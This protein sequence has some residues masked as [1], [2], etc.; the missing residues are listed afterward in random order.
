MAELGLCCGPRPDLYQPPHHHPQWSRSR[1]I[2][3]I[4]WAH[5]PRHGFR[6]K[7]WLAEA[8]TSFQ[9]SLW[10]H[11]VILQ[12]TFTGHLVSHLQPIFLTSVHSQPDSPFQQLLWAVILS[13]LEHFQWRSIP[14]PVGLAPVESSSQ[15]WLGQHTASV[16]IGIKEFFLCHLSSPYHLA[17]EVVP[18]ALCIFGSNIT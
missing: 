14:Y 11:L 12:N 6:V 15:D 4:P 16:L 3:P 5:I 2:T 13:L 9:P 8:A 1:A 10:V 7:S 18:P 17:P